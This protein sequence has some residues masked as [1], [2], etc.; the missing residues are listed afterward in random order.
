MIGI[1]KPDIH[2]IIHYGLPMS[3]ESYYQQTGRGGRDGK[4][5]SA[6]LLWDRESEKTCHW[7]ATSEAKK[8]G[9]YNVGPD[10]VKPMKGLACGDFSCR[11]KCMMSYFNEDTR[12]LPREAVENCCD[13]CDTKRLE[14][15]D[16]HLITKEFRAGVFILMRTLRKVTS[17]SNLKGLIGIIMGRDNQDARK[18]LPTCKTF[19]LF[20][21]G[22]GHSELW[23]KALFYQIMDVDNFVACKTQI[24]TKTNSDGKEYT[25]SFFIYTLGTAGKYY[26]SECESKF[27]LDMI[28]QTNAFPPR[29]DSD[30]RCTLLRNQTARTTTTTSAGKLFHDR[31]TSQETAAFWGVNNHGS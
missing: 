25:I 30:I 27:P 11:R 4:P 18:V 22:K 6:I 24:V 5:T 15:N 23:W 1:D 7:L 12:S 8:H 19:G 31:W 17:C 13:L 2:L 26:L 21:S 29:Y 16:K 20:G 9:I 10:F 28:Y 3:I 14:G